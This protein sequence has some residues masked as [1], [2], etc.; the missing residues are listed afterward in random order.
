MG[1]NDV[2]RILAAA[3]FKARS[4]TLKNWS[5]QNPVL[6]AG[7]PGV[8]IGLNT[9]GDGLEPSNRKVKIGDGITPWNNL[10]WWEGVKGE[11]GKDYVLTK[12]DKE[13]IAEDIKESLGDIE[14]ALDRI[15]EIQNSL[16]GGDE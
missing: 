2:V 1:N 14:T 10:S 9:I 4:D 12:A 15:I 6:L 7:E 5:E 11:D 8:V 16:I 3:R 13:E